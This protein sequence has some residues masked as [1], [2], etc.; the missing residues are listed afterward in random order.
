MPK[1]APP[2]GEPD[3]LSG[4]QP[5][6][7]LLSAGNAL[8]AEGRRALLP[9]GGLPL[10]H[11]VRAFFAEHPD[12]P[13]ILVGALPYDR[14]EPAHLFQPERIVTDGS[15]PVALS[16]GS[17]PAPSSRWRVTPE[18]RPEIFA[19]SVS[20]AVARLDGT[21][22]KIVLSR[23]LLVAADSPIDIA[24]LLSRLAADD[25]A[26]TFCVPLPPLPAGPPRALVGATPEL[27][28][29]RRGD[30][31]V[32]HPLAGS[33]RRVAD[34]A[35]D[36]AAADSL[37]HSDKDRREH[38]LVVEMILDQLAPWCREL[39]TPD[40]TALTR[41]ASMWHLGTRIEGRLKDLTTSSITLAAL[42]HPTPAVCG[43]PREAAARAIADLEAYD[44]GF[45]A[46]AVGWCDES[47]DGSWHVAIRCA[48]IA[49]PAAR[50]YAGAGIVPGSDPAAE[51]AETSAKFAALLEALG[52]DES[53][54]PVSGSR[55]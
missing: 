27:L 49:G 16:N 55:R 11:A 3:A 25:H 45:Y 10:A 7:A 24:A 28:V 22:R 51:T 1:W 40:G 18:P 33:A 5:P 8:V 48:E 37:A 19:D 38:R 50:L 53:G 43:V 36:R 4:G 6:F 52:I 32:S 21:L 39:A 47:G 46:G 15:R 31:V 29:E 13:R 30:R 14:A 44:R 17:A 54:R 34:P 35:A 2:S 12:G 26:A 23:S 42:L 9:S 41:T 20:R